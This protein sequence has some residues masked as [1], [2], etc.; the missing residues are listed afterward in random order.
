MIPNH[1]FQLIALT[2]MEPPISFGADAVRDEKAK[3]LH[4]MQPPHP[5]T[6]LNCAVRGQYGEGAIEGNPKL[7]YRS[8]PNVRPDSN[9]PTFA[10]LKLF[11][12]NWRWAG[13]PFYIRTGKRMAQRV[14]EITIQFRQAPFILFRD[15]PVEQ[16][17]SN[18]LVIQIQ[19]EE[20]IW[21][22]FGAKVPGPSVNIGGV[23]MNFKYSDYFG[24]SPSTGYETLLY[25][26][27]VGD[28]TLFQRADMVEAGWSVVQPVLDAWEK[29]P[30]G[31]FPNYPAGSWGPRAADELLER[32]GRHWRS[33]MG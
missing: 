5:D 17:P 15:T 30:P 11:I 18:L 3:I 23:Q 10:A 29:A 22:R 31:E 27:M 14:S 13:V 20:G 24:R 19:P 4:A 7:A 9:T 6:C 16:L 33:T 1:I 25:D 2:A 21:L 32:D 12:D 26:C 28:S 8:E